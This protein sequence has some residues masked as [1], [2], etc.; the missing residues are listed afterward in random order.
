MKLSIVVFVFLRLDSALGL[1]L[2]RHRG[3]GSMCGRSRRKKGQLSMEGGHEI[4]ARGYES[5]QAAGV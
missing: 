5:I 2:K 1:S 3:Q 4:L